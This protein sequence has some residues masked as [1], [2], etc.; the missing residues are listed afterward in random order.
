[1]KVLDQEVA[2]TRLVA[3]QLAHRSARFGLDAPAL[4]RLTLP[5][6]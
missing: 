5:L 3:E 2:A 4:G 6:A 1:V